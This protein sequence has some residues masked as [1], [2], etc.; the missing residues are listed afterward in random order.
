MLV[1]LINQLTSYRWK[2]FL[3]VSSLGSEVS[4]LIFRDWSYWSSKSSTAYSLISYTDNII[5][6]LKQANASLDTANLITAE[7]LK[8]PLKKTQSVLDL[9]SL[10]VGKQL[11][12]F[13]GTVKYLGEF[14]RNHSVIIKPLHYWI[15]NYDKT[16][17]IVWTPEIV[18]AFN[19]LILQ[20]SERPTMHFLIETAP[21][22]VHWC[23]WLWRC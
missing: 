23:I 8:M 3:R 7:Q 14:I 22:K 5:N 4:V 19:V 15:S 11:K 6:T 1:S 12:R 2:V 10:I 16:R 13:L 20:L 17:K 21:I 9:Q 18:A